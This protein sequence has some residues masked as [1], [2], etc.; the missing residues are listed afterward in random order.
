MKSSA[1]VF[2]CRHGDV[3]QIELPEAPLDIY[4]ETTYQLKHLPINHF[5]FKSIKSQIKRNERIKQIEQRREQKR[6]RKMREVEEKKRENP[7]F[8][9][10]AFL[11][12][13]DDEM[14]EVLEPIYI[15]DPPSA[16]L[17]LQVTIDGTLWV[18]MAGYDAGYVYELS[19][20][21]GDLLSFN[22][23]P[24]A[25]DT[26]M[27]SFVYRDDLLILGMGDGQLRVNR[28][29]DGNWR[30]LSDFWTLSMHD[31]LFGRI[32]KIVFSFDG[33][34]LVSI[35]SDGN[36]FVYKWNIQPVGARR[37]STTATTLVEAPK[38]VF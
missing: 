2:G 37:K 12:D 24:D 11:A 3:L 6:E 38:V 35:G 15:P 27:H 7:R 19:L 22:E 30:D 31:N 34:F 4:T 26:E 25:T 28:I 23:I 10:E 29:R 9:V 8:D 32:P 36:L 18:S 5:K 17:W 33:K 1:A 20:D 13:S 16:I 14:E 21:D